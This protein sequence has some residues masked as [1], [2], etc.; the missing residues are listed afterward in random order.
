MEQKEGLKPSKQEEKQ[1]KGN[2]P[3]REVVTYGVVTEFE[4]QLMEIEK[5][6]SSEEKPI[7]K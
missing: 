4:K 3:E 1:M 5:G 7:V 6:K 2:N